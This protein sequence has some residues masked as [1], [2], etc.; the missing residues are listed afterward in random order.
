MSSSGSAPSPGLSP[1]ASLS[2]ARARVMTADLRNAH[3]AYRPPAPALQPGG[4]LDDTTVLRR[5][6]PA[7]AADGE[8]MLL[9]LGGAGALRIGTNL[10]LSFRAMDLFHMLILVPDR[11]VCLRLWEVLPDVACVWW[12]SQWSRPRPSSLYN[13][14]FPRQALALYEA[15]KVLLERLVLDHGLNVLHLDSD[16]VWFANPYPLLKTA[17]AES[18]LVFQQDNPFVNAGVFYVQGVRRGDGAAWVLQELN[19]RIER[20]TYRPESVRDLPHSGWARAPY[21]ANAD[22]QANL[23]DVVASSLSEMVSFAGGV[24]FPEARFK[25]RFAPRRCLNARGGGGSAAGAAATRGCDGVAEAR[26]RMADFRWG[27]GLSDGG[28]VALGRRRVRRRSVERRLDPHLCQA[29]RDGGSEGRLL[30]PGNA[31]AATGRLLI[32]PAWLFAHFPYGHFFDAFRQCHASSWRWPPRSAT[33]RRLCMPEHRVPTVM[34]HMA[35]LRQEAWGRRVMMRAFGVWQEGADA[36]APEAWISARARDAAAAAADDDAAGRRHAWSATGRLL[37]TVDVVR[38]SAFASMQEYDR[39]AARLLVLGLLLDRRVVMPPIECGASYMRKALQ[40]R[41]L[42]GLEIGCGADA[43][44]IWLPYPHHIEPFCSGIDFLYD[45]DYRALLERGTAAQAAAAAAVELPIEQLRLLWNASHH[46]TPLRVHADAPPPL[47]DHAQ[48]VQLRGG[49]QLGTLFSLGGGSSHA[50]AVRAGGESPHDQL[51]WLPLG[52]FRTEQWRA[53][54][55][56]RLEA[57]LR[58][59]AAREGAHP[60]SAGLGLSDAQVKIVKTCLKSLA[61]SRE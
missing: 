21:F 19:R 45:I 59:P 48:V 56:R 54:L 2:Q 14:N 42:R 4:D 30:V 26:R 8:I 43:Q 18:Q 41:H 6:L 33:E 29:S 37:T 44:C 25:E 35:G 52:G 32:A 7:A 38:P 9:C 57:Y 1:L 17:Y 51:S 28:S 22:E 61:T 58:A 34:V 46:S 15:R 39:F 50:G 3:R 10:V 31:S 12:P 20:F 27:Q 23:N 16:T 11:P 13:D 36:V 47:H 40:A 49:R 55:P 53:P 60:R 24:E 5:I